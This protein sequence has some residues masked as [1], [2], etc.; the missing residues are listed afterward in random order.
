MPG[1]PLRYSR[2]AYNWKLAPLVHAMRDLLG[3]RGLS[4]LLR[5]L[6]VVRNS[7]RFIGD[8]AAVPV[9]IA[10]HLG[11][12]LDLPPALFVVA[13]VTAGV[14]ISVCSGSGDRAGTVPTTTAVAAAAGIIGGIRIAVTAGDR[15]RSRAIPT[16][17]AP[18]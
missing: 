12:Q 4:W 15:G 6:C 13:G 14:R 3:Q 8:F 9:R 5:Q 17:A 1:T 16:T 11:C 10:N 7:G 2:S 18:G